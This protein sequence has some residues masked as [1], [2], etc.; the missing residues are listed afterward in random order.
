VILLKDLFTWSR[1]YSHVPPD[2][3]V[4][5]W[6]FLVLGFTIESRPR[7][8]SS[9]YLVPGPPREWN[10]LGIALPPSRRH[11]QPSCAWFPRAHQWCETFSSNLLPRAAPIKRVLKTLRGGSKIKVTRYFGSNF[12]NFFENWM[13]LA[14]R[15]IQ[16][17][18]AQEVFEE[19]IICSD[20][21]RRRRTDDC[22][23]RSKRLSI[24]SDLSQSVDN[25]NK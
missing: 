25:F 11:A 14:L 23:H 2:H 3:I 18:G 24:D 1:Y 19:K 7:V 15:C 6:A 10:A 5:L 13:D 17:G 16:H 21:L 12:G 9:T 8:L 22:Y 20:F 4:T